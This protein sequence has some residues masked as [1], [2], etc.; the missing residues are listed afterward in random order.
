MKILITGGSGYI[1]SHISKDLILEGYEPIILDNLSNSFDMTK[2]I[3][4]ITGIKPIFYKNF[5][6]K[7]ILDEIFTKYKISSVIHLA[8]LKSVSESVQ[9]PLLYYENNINASVILLDRMI[10]HNINKI[11]F[12]SS[13][14]V[15]GDFISPP[16][17]EEYPLK[18]IN[19]YATT[20]I[21]I[22]NILNDVCSA[23]NIFKCICL[24]YFNPIGCDKSGLLFD[25]PKSNANNL[26][27]QIIKNLKEKSTLKI[28]G[29]N[30]D[31]IDGTCIRDY[32][33]ISDLSKAHIAS[34]KKLEE[35]EKSYE[36]INIGTGK[37][38]SVLEVIKTFEEVNNVKIKYKFVKKRKGDAA[39]SFADA[40][41]A[42]KILNW[43]SKYDL[44]EMC[45]YPNTVL[46]K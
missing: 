4:K 23:N 26:L 5:I 39:I 20:K 36:I 10:H 35:L 11:V 34:L 3:K 42:K 46:A 33:H 18:S 1:G 12:S 2:S 7:K 30:Y 31:T 29:K 21:Q 14:T 6:N 24:R 43:S 27:P 15:Y 44:S 37:G 8:G 25:N 13:A 19:P 38:H 22:E 41:K 28:Y 32:I 9:N 45:R 16:Y 17:K 40:N